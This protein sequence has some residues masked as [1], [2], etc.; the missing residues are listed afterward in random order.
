MLFK[1]ALV[2]AASGKLGGLVASHNSGGQYLRALTIPTDPASPQQ[3]AVRNAVVSLS[4]RWV[5][6][7]TVA[8]RSAWDVYGQNTTLINRLGDPIHVSGLAQYVR[9]NVPRRQE[10]N[11][12]RVDDAPTIYDTG[13][14][15]AIAAVAT[16]A[17][18]QLAVAFEEAD[19]WVD[20]D[21]A[22]LMIYASRPQNP[23]IN[24]FKGPYRFAGTIL[25]DSTTP[26]TSPDTIAVP[27]PV[28]AGQRVFFYGRV[29]R[30]DGRLTGRQV[31]FAD[32][33]A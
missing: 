12:T 10:S 4:N 7:L 16:E 18:Q 5:N 6:N 21:D 31:G 32:V 19:D 22:G 28:V 14:F 9:S 30:A 25:G 26:P 23:T 27:F 2:T 17:S 20:E 15:G 1:S 11:L 13:D 24:F 29:A 3:V 8:Q 33:T